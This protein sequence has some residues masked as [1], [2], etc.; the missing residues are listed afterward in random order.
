M[1]KYVTFSILF[2]FFLVLTSPI[3]GEATESKEVSSERN[4]NNSNE[5]NLASDAKS[6]ILMEKDTGTI[7]FNKNSD[8]R[9]PPA[10]VT[11]LMT[12]LLVMEALDK[13]ELALDETIRISENA[14]S[15]GGSQLFLE[16]GEEMSVEDLLKGV[17]IASGNDAS[18]A[19]AE[20]V[21][22]TEEAFVKAMNEKAKILGL[23]DS[24]FENTTGLPTENHYSSA[25]DLAVIAR[26]LLAY[27]SITDYT[28]IYEDYLREGQENEFWLVNTNKLVRSYD[29]LD[30]LKTGYTNEAKYGL[31]ATA[32]KE[33]M[34]V[35]SVVLG[36]DS[37][38]KRNSYTTEMLDYAFQHYKT[39]KLFEKGEQITSFTLLRAKDPNVKVVTSN[40]VSIL[41]QTGE[42]TEN[43]TT[44]IHMNQQIEAPLDK[45]EQV[46]TLSVEKGK[47]TLSETPLVVNEK[48]D[49]ASFYTLWKRNIKN[50]VKNQ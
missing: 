5:I 12:L 42:T 46:G 9:L 20:R 37:A 3:L 27:E 40:P 39:K 30:G 34:R 41:H 21:A 10:S 11:K 29:G 44:T 26:A 23:Q 47:K 33:G 1:N 14:S 25:H 43:I 7:I 18:V 2:V 17:A 35:I 36:A 24:H 13:N 16:A 31:T 28:S 50:I 45:G 38:K 22:G 49:K 48:I 32:E 4:S 15:M 8:E 6:A 19:L